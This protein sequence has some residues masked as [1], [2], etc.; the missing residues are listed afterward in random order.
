MSQ[1][2]IFVKI[3]RLCKPKSNPPQCNSTDIEEVQQTL[4]FYNFA[5]CISKFTPKT[6]KVNRHINAAEHNCTCLATSKIQS[7]SN[8]LKIKLNIFI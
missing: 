6:V 4:G 2:T 8:L 5:A 7:I 1:I 3:F